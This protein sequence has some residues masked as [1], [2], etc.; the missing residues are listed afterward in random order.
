MY[1]KDLS[2]VNYKNLSQVEFQ[3]SKKLNCFIGNNG[4]GKTNLLDCIYYLSFCKSYF[5]VSD[6]HNVK[7]GEEFFVLQGKYEREG[8]EENIYCGLKRGNKKKFSRNKKEYKRLSGHI[9][10]LPLVMISPSD[11][12]LILGV[13]EGRRKFIDSVISQFDHI[14][15]DNLIKYNRALVQRNSLLKQFS[16]NRTF[17]SDSLEI[18]D[19]QLVHLGEEIHRKRFEFIGD[20]LPIFQ[21]YYKYI[22]KE[23]ESVELEY[24]SHLNDADFPDLLKSSLPKDRLLQYT[25]VGIHKDDLDFK[26]EGY[27]IKKLGSQGQK[28]TYL[29]AL[30][31]AQFEFIRNVNESMPILLLDDIFDKLDSTRVE[32]VV[33]LVSEKN[34]GQIFITD[35]N[36]EHLDRLI[37]GIGADYRI[38]RIEDGNVL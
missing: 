29:T 34:F 12:S 9:G 14:Y 6:I 18:W 38:F 7:H 22:S 28:K 8:E 36:R 27:P 3:F 25:T 15:L 21:N 1:L 16:A 24:I 17:D 19:E 20:I 26:I 2:V 33:K 11:T 37:Q 10:L 32:Q 5:N 30:K 13:S 35:T 23:Y 31:L 4:V